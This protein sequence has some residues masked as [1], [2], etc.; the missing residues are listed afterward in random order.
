MTFSELASPLSSITTLK[1]GAKINE[2]YPIVYSQLPLKY[3]HFEHNLF[4]NGGRHIADCL[5]MRLES[6]SFRPFLTAFKKRGNLM[7]IATSVFWCCF[8]NKLFTPV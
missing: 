2:K 8:S 3:A 4:F 6:T 1:R 5:V 7:M